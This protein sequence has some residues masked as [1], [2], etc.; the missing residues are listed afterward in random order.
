MALK[1][2][3][4]EAIEVAE[5][6]LNDD[7]YSVLGN[8]LLAEAATAA[9]FPRTAVFAWDLVMKQQPDDKANTMK[10]CQ[11]LVNNGEV[12]KAEESCAALARAHPTDQEVLQLSKNLTASPGALRGRVR[13]GGLWRGRLPRGT[14]G[15]GGGG[16]ARA[17]KSP[18]GAGVHRRET[19]SLSTRSG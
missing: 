17:G 2:D 13:Q 6:I 7:P 14:K 11:A 15:R 3:P 18:L 5:Q 12:A 8:K 1:K 19:R 16:A 10:Y 9:G 4:L